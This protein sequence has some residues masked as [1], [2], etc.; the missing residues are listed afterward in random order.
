MG[1]LAEI[2]D[3]VH[4]LSTEQ[5]EDLVAQAKAAP[6]TWI[7]NPGPQTWAFRCQADELFYGGEAGGGKTDLTIGAAITVHSQSLILRRY[8]KDAKGMAD[9]MLDGILSSRYGWNGQDQ[10]FRDGAGRAI[11]FGGC[12][13][14]KDKQRYK[15]RPH[16]LIAFDEISDFLESQYRFITAWNRS[17]KPKQRS[18]VICTGNPPTSAE[19]LWVIKYWGAWL[20]PTHPNP[21]MEGELRWYTTVGGKDVEVDGPG[22]HRIPGEPKPVYARSRTFIRAKLSDNPDLSRDNQYE[23]VLDS[24][25]EELRAAYR[26]GKFDSA[27]KD[28]PWAIIPSSWVRAAMDRWIETPPVNVPMCAMAGDIAQGGDDSNTIAMRYDGWY[29]P[30]VVV[31]GS[32]TPLGGPTIAGLLLSK[33]QDQCPVVVDCG[34][35]YGGAVYAHLKSNG[36]M[37]AIAWQGG[38]GT[39]SRTKDQ[40]LR[41]KNKR[42]E[43][44]WR[45]R[46]ALDPSQPQGSTVS[47][48]NDAELMSDLTAP[49]FEVRGEFIVV[50]TKEDLCSRLGRSPDKGDAVVMCWMAGDKIADSFKQWQ[51]RG[52]PTVIHSHQSARRK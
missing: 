39:T 27:I 18:R 52:R 49:T 36:V 51:N 6:E 12:Q 47:L 31:P 5:R 10:I 22:P 34:G 23:A 2:L 40:K 26:D 14:E 37:N 21:A 35:G 1:V 15:G 8:N 38:S 13:E 17:A 7:P 42:A 44:L 24:L 11:E 43:S 32:Q 50:E 45:F 4:T 25:P 41:F 28:N 19:G 46:E 33:R 30:I 9:R 16:D 20:D 48:P 3:K 29:A